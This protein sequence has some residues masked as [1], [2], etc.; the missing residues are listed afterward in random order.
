VHRANVSQLLTLHKRAN[1]SENVVGWYSTMTK[2]ELV[3][4]VSVA[5]HDF[6]EGFCA[7]PIHIVVDTRLRDDKIDVHGFVAPK[8]TLAKGYESNGVL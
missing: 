5:L 8:S 7:K 2:G 1:A 3:D 4:D 6:F